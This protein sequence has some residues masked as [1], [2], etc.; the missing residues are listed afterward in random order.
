MARSGPSRRGAAAAGLPRRVL[1]H[2]QSERTTVRQ[3][4]S[5]LA[6]CVSVTLVAGVVLGA[7]EGLLEEQPGLLI[8]VP[9]AIGMRGAILGA[10]AA[11]LGTGILTGQYDGRIER[12]SF[13]RQNLE[14]AAL[15]TVF[16][17]GLSALVA[18][19]TAH[20]FG[21]RVISLP[22]LALVSMVGAL[23]ST[24]IGLP[25]TLLLART[26]QTRSRV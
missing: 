19:G 24:A 2:W 7:M 15:L 17:A 18:W 20:L 9:S 25:T 3:G 6:I 26:A 22:E 16:T 1:R 4:F 14:A 21:Q 13:I 10:L 12:G 8:L 23:A 5:A 11:R